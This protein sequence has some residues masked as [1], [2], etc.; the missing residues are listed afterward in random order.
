[1]T[2]TLKARAFRADY[3]PSGVLTAPYVIDTTGGLPP[4]ETPPPDPATVAPPLSQVELTPFE[5]QVSFLYGGPTPIQ[6][7][8][9]PGT[10]QD[11]R[12]AVLR[13]RVLTRDGQPLPGARV[14]IASRTEF[15]YTISRTDGMFD[16]V[17]NGGGPVT[18]EY[19][20]NGFLPVQRVVDPP[21]HDYA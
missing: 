10:L 13:G 20:R 1:M 5:D 12:V 3:T 6:Q 8:L 21:W 9:V 2:T 18:L 4:G 17:V 11:F 14:T 15:G 19:T 16:L 7:G